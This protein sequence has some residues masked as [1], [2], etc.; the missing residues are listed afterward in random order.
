ML[1]QEAKA[2]AQ[3]ACML[4]SLKIDSF[5]SRKTR[6]AECVKDDG[7]WDGS[8]METL[9]FKEC[10]FVDPVKTSSDLEICA[11][12]TSPM[13]DD[14]LPGSPGYIAKYYTGPAGTGYPLPGSP[15]D[16]TDMDNAP[17]TDVKEPEPGFEEPFFLTRQQRQQ[18][19]VTTCCTHPPLNG[20]ETE[21][22]EED[23]AKPATTTTT[24]PPTVLDLPSGKISL[25]HL[26]PHLRKQV[27]T[28]NL[29]TCGFCGS[30]LVNG[31]G[32]PLCGGVAG[33]RV[34]LALNGFRDGAITD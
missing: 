17:K 19:C 26:P 16:T 22:A 8:F 34:L 29:P 4:D 28:K 7:A 12:H 9:D 3:V 32:Q 31:Q 11:S 27:D 33:G 23:S 20:W 10:D 18:E 24:T 13:N 30:E 1:K 6:L 5:D 15:D 25:E 14:D 21:K 2:I